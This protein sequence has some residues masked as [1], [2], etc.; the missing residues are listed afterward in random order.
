LLFALLA[1]NGPALSDDEVEPINRLAPGDAIDRL[2]EYTDTAVVVINIENSAWTDEIFATG[3]ACVSYVS[4]S[5]SLR[6]VKSL[7]SSS[8]T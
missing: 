3:A 4:P 8:R 1:R 2:C 6:T 7:A 5:S